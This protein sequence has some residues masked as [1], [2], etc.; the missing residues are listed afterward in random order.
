MSEGASIDLHLSFANQLEGLGLWQWAIF[1][2]LFLPDFYSKKNNVLG[3]LMRNLQVP[4]TEDSLVVEDQLTN[5]FHLPVC[6]IHAVKGYKSLSQTRHHEAFAYFCYAGMWDKASAIARNELLPSLVIEGMF[7]D[8]HKILFMLK[9]GKGC[10]QSW[11]SEENRYLLFIELLNGMAGYKED[12]YA[13]KVSAEKKF[14]DFCAVSS[15]F[16]TKRN[17]KHAVSMAEMSRKMLNH[18]FY[19]D[20][21][22]M[23]LQD[24]PMPTDYIKN[25]L[26]KLM[27]EKVFKTVFL[28]N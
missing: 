13:A 7:E 10:I 9:K 4:S 17:L 23:Y 3:I 20:F 27:W 18:P 26:D 5:Y 12:D 2:T 14:V 28:L 15:S 16:S 19:I 8:I 6:W 25:E 21:K 11:E 22:Q 24:L 1:V